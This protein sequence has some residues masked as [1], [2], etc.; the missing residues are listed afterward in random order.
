MKEKLDI[1]NDIGEYTG[2]TATPDEC[3]SKGYW[4]RAVFCLIIN[5]DG[6][7]LLQKRSTNK[8]LWPNKWDVTVGG[9]VRS[10]ELGRN[11]LI[12]ECKEEM[13]LEIHD[14]EIKFIVSSISKYNKNNYINNHFDEFY[15]IIKDVN[16]EEI[17]LQK[18]EVDEA[19]YF[20]QEELLK[21][22]NNNYDGITEK[23]VSWGF[24]KNL[25]ESSMIN[26]FIKK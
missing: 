18:E 23:T 24:V 22:I 10:G 14:D 13:G 19:R 4:H 15:L 5:S 1:L 8:K 20:T 16:I 11:A 2:K 17:V 26:S 6:K 9:H 12:R 3:H 21:R 25:I 7:I